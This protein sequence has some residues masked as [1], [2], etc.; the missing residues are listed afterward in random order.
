[1][2]VT[3]AENGIEFPIGA[4]RGLIATLSAFTS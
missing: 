2:R 4:R 3:F 1:M